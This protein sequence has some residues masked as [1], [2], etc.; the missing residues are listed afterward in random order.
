MTSAPIYHGNI[1]ELFL[2]NRWHK[3]I[4]MADDEKEEPVVEF[5]LPGDNENITSACT[6]YE[7]TKDIDPMLLSESQQRVLKR[8]QRNSLFIIDKAIQCIREVYETE[9]EEST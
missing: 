8:I 9:E 4:V 3:N 2:L 7:L 6:A 5:E 1:S